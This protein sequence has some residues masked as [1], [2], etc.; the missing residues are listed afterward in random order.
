MEEVRAVREADDRSTELQ[1]VV[2][3]HHQP[4]IVAAGGVDGQAI[5]LPADAPHGYR[6]ERSLVRHAEPA[7]DIGPISPGSSTDRS[8]RRRSRSGNAHRLGLDNVTGAGE[9][10]L[11]IGGRSTQ[12]RAFLLIAPIDPVPCE[13]LDE[14][15]GQSEV[16]SHHKA[17]R[18]DVANQ[19]VTANRLDAAAYGVDLRLCEGNSLS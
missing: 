13:V 6:D 4:Q 19:N 12:S 14:N 18:R 1:R 16:T 5:V 17:E 2:S 9:R 15:R 3:W 10:L 8:H 7:T 11:Q